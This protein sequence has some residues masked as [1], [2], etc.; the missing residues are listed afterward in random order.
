MTHSVFMSRLLSGATVTVLAFAATP[1]LA[2][3]TLTGIDSV[4]DRI[5]DIDR[6]AR[7]ELERAEDPFRFGNPEYRNGLSGSASLGFTGKTGETNSS[8]F[9]LGARLRFAQG[10]LVQNIG[11]VLDYAESASVK[12]KEDIFAIYDANYYINDSVYGF[13]LGRLKMDGLA[14]EVTEVKTDGF[15][16]VGPGYR[17]VNS[18]DVSWRV[19]A[20]IGVSY[21]EDGNGESETETGYIASSRLYWRL[22]DTF[23]ATNDTDVLKSDSAL[24]INNDLGL[25]VK[26]SELF[27]TRISYLTEFNDSRE[28]MAENKLGISLVYSF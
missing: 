13:V 7:L 18:A 20:G 12:S 23:F 19:Q 2:Q 8:E 15:I 4:D 28:E 10:P 26:M 17:I 5:D 11:V 16:G 25:N 3:T 1:G 27:A 21:L 14:D 6:A 22:S 24:R 9:N